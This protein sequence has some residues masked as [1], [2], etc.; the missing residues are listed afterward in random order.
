MAFFDY[1]G[2][3]LKDP[4][5]WVGFLAILIGSLG[6]V[7]NLKKA[8]ATQDVKSYSLLY[9]VCCVLADSLFALQ[10][11]MKGS[12]TLTVVRVVTGIYFSYFLYLYLKTNY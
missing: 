3:H 2:S 5:E 10:G 7:S 12:V 11:Y 9:L 6:A 8:N 4:A 1:V